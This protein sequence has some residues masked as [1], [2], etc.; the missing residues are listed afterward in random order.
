MPVSG[1]PV[2]GRRIEASI[3]KYSTFNG[4]FCSKTGNVNKQKILKSPNYMMPTKQREKLLTM[5]EEVK[6]K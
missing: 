5:D 3:V 2:G 6:R 1:V 4:R